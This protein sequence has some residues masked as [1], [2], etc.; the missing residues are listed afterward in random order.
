MVMRFIVMKM[1]F[2]SDLQTSVSIYLLYMLKILIY[3][4]ITVL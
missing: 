1:L 4:K 2:I 3:S